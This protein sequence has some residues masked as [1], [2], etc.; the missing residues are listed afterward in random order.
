MKALILAAGYATRLYPLTIDQP[1]CLLSVG[2]KTILDR[3]YEKMENISGLNEISIVTNDKFYQKLEDWKNGTK[4]KISVRIFND[5]TTSNDNRL[6]AIGDLGF[7]LKEIG[8]QED[9]LMLASDNIF[10]EDLKRFCEFANKK[11]EGASIALYDIG[12]KSFAAKKYGVVEMDSQNKITNI[13]EKPEFPKTSLIGMGLYY[14]PKETLSLV[15]EYLRWEGA[16][17]AP[18]YYITWL[19]GRIKIFGYTFSGSWYD[20]GDI[21]SLEEADKVFLSQK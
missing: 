8:T 15:D 17:D 18:G 3:L 1:K 19:L 20:I 13:E 14:F 6:G 2:K 16:K 5:R 12:D 10:D 11:R 7:A 21:R 9:L 4:R